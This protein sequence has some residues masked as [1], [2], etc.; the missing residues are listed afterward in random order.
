VS[1]PRAVS[2]PI[3]HAGEVDDVPTPQQ[4]R[5]AA[6]ACTI[7]AYAAGLAGVAA[8]TLVLRD[9]DLVFAIIL[10]VITFAVGAALMGVAVLVRASA[11]LSATIARLESEVRV[12]VADRAGRDPRPA[13]EQ[14][15]WSGHAPW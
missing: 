13:T 8:G 2:R 15:P 5:S 12:L 4:L 6:R 9:G 7:L 10:W 3:G 11:G 14:D 1:A